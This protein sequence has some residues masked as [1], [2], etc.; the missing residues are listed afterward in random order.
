MNEK[1]QEDEYNGDITSQPDAAI[2]Y[3]DLKS[4]WLRLL[5]LRRTLKSAIKSGIELHDSLYAANAVLNQLI[6]TIKSAPDDSKYTIKL[7]RGESLLK[8]NNLFQYILFWQTD[9]ACLL[10]DMFSKRTGWEQRLIARHLMLTLFEGLDDLRQMLNKPFR[11]LLIQNGLEHHFE[12]LSA[13][14]KTLVVIGKK[15]EVSYRDFRNS[16]TAHRDHD[17]VR[18]WELLKT[19]DPKKTLAVALEIYEWTN[20]FRSFYR[21]IE[22]ELRALGEIEPSLA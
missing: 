4:G 15:H 11:D 9:Y 12:E 14:R 18:Q 1:P 17:A 3:V 7:G 19:L 2:E 13:F 22:T 6:D 20:K 16:V 8:L 5:G 10:F 21:I